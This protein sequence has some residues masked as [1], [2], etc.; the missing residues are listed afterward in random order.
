[1]GPSAPVAAVGQVCLVC[2]VTIAVISPTRFPRP[3]LAQHHPT[4]THKKTKVLQIERVRVADGGIETCRRLPSG[5][6]EEVHVAQVPRPHARRGRARDQLQ[7]HRP[8]QRVSGWEGVD[9]S[10]PPKKIFSIACFFFI[11]S[12]PFLTIG[13]CCM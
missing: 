11:F 10:S 7:E 12:I 4:A 6:D 3:P 2:T 13:S 1:M 5:Q 8:A 9:F